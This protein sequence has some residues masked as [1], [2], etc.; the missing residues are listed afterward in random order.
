LDVCFKAR[1]GDC[2][3]I[4][5]FF[6]GLCRLGGIPTRFI[7]GCWAGAMNGVHCWA[8]FYLP[9]V[10]WVPID[11]SP[12]CN[13]GYLSNNHLPLVKAG[14]M[15]FDVQENQG[16]KDCGFIQPG[17]WF[18]LYAGGSEGNHIDVEF[19]IASYAKDISQKLTNE[20]TKKQYTSISNTMRDK[21]YDRAIQLGWQLSR[22]DLPPEMA[23]SVQY[24][25]AKSY[26]AKH[27]PIMAASLLLPMADRKPKTTACRNAE[28]LLK[29][30]RTE[31]LYLSDLNLGPIRQ[32]WGQPHAN[33][34][35]EGRAISIG[36]RRFEKGIGTH[37][38]SV[39]VIQ[40]N[41]SIKE[42]SAFVGVDDE[43][44]KGQGSVEF[45]VLGDES[46]LWQSGV[47]KAGDA[48]KQVCVKIKEAKKLVLKVTDAGDG[49]VCDHAD[50]ADAQVK[51]SGI[52]PSIIAPQ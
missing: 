9:D 36:G 34:S 14:G 4:A 44:S 35:V 11:H 2:G 48:P 18:F 41:D 17:L 8:E 46:I 7:A 39:C 22:C 12:A 6:T 26:Y 5:H 40:T 19:D 45:F 1:K 13:F 30:V 33:Q 21:Q 10:G 32:G 23:D 49:G 28:L 38:E 31:D 3:A 15:K 27:A 51:L 24:T 43:I 16:G 50:W 29:Q 25:L 42:F 47:M 37:A 52:Y 20:E